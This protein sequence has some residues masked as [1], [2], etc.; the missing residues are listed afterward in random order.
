[1]SEF[2]AHKPP[3]KAERRMAAVGRASAERGGDGKGVCGG[4]GIPGGV[5]RG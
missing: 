5:V 3:W 4:V 1:M 2:Y